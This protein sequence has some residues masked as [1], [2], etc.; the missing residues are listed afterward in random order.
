LVVIAVTVFAG[1]CTQSDQ[2]ERYYV[3]KPP[4][5][6]ADAENPHSEIQALAGPDVGPMA[7]SG[8][9]VVKGPLRLLGAIVPRGRKYWFFKV[10][11]PADAVAPHAERFTSFVRSIR[12]DGGEDAE[13]TW[14]LPEGWQ[15]DPGRGMRLASIRL[16]PDDPTLEMSVIPLA[17]QGSDS[18]IYV[19]SNINRWRRQVG[20]GEIDSS[21]LAEGTTNIPLDG[22]TAIMIDV[23]GGNTAAGTE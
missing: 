18:D 7:R 19:L 2:I 14:T 11:G 4:A 23:T 22:A 3:N 12:F 5:G 10:T 20:L 9:T 15:Q 17:F 21:R 1:G 8:E 6:E 13:P 16:D